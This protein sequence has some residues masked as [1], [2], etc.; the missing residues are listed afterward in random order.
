MAAEQ[1]HESE[2]K[3]IKSQEEI[4]QEIAELARGNKIEEEFKGGLS[5]NLTAGTY[6]IRSLHDME[7]IQFIL[8]TQPD[9]VYNAQDCEE[10]YHTIQTK[11]DKAGYV[12]VGWF[13]CASGY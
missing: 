11:L 5:G 2:S 3:E 1:G 10:G 9:T 6:E 8:R 7:A 4:D 13:N 12:C